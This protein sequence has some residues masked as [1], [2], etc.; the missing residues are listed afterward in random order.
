MTRNLL[1]LALLATVFAGAPAHADCTPTYS[2]TP[3]A[4]TWT[5]WQNQA[6]WALAYE[7]HGSGLAVVSDECAGQ[8]DVRVQVTDRAEHGSPVT[9]TEGHAWDGTA[10]DGEFRAYA[11]SDAF[12][13]YYDPLGLTVRGSSVVELR[14]SATYLDIAT[15]TTVPLGCAMT[16]TSVTPLPT[17][18]MLET[19]P[20][21]DCA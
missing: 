3:N 10:P 7:W 1:A 14:V 15:Q 4:L 19:G 8:L 18:P 13:V 17:E 16:R 2:I 20:V 11:E 6:T 5:R 9:G 21:E 12:V